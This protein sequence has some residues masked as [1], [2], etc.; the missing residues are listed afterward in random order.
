MFFWEKSLEPVFIKDENNGE[1]FYVRHKVSSNDLIAS[2]AF[3][4][5]KEHWKEKT[6]I[7]E[8]KIYS[9]QL[10][11]LL[12]KCEIDVYTEVLTF[13]SLGNLLI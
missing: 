12:N 5:I 4:Y 2:E 1:K 10:M 6:S 8:K 7:T 11:A 13:F 3:K 9:T